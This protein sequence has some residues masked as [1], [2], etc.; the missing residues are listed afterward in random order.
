MAKSNKT[1]ALEKY[2]APFAVNL[3]NFMD[4]HP[5]T[6]VK[7]TRKQLADYLN[8]RPQ[9]VSCYCM[10]KSIWLIMLA[11]QTICVMLSLTMPMQ[12]EM[13]SWHP[14]AINCGHQN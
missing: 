2:N 6:G 13:K 7:T 12:T 4:I 1:T 9:T 11:S 5:V 8:V 10:G 3:R 14:Y